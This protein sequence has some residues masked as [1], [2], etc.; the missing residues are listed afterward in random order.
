MSKNK[1]IGNSYERS[2]SYKLSEWLT[3][4]KDADVCWRESSSGGRA[5]NRKSKQKETQNAGD[6]IPTDLNYQW[7]FDKFYVEAKSYKDFNS[8]I[9]N[10][11]NIKSNGLFKQ[12]CKTIL[13]CPEDKIPLMFC[14][15]RDRKTPELLFCP[16]YL[17]TKTQFN[18]MLYKVSI[19]DNFLIDNKL[20]LTITA[21]SV[22][23]KIILQDE[24]FKNNTARGLNES[25]SEVPAKNAV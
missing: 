25:V 21:E 5:T 7:F 22:I 13:Q 11:N 3:G 16:V 24:F 4:K 23:F 20:N 18:E 2:L 6:I 14:K 15:V 8:L 17:D 1:S 12:W 19:P 9:I 10:Q